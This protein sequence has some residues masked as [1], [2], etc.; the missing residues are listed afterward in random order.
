MICENF[1]R[2]SRP[3]RWDR[4]GCA[5][6]DPASAEELKKCL[7]KAGGRSSARAGMRSPRLWSA[8]R[9]IARRSRS[10]GSER[11]K[12]ASDEHVSLT[13]PRDDGRK[14]EDAAGA[15]KQPASLG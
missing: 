10:A 1:V 14:D 11:G 15:S 3:T 5:N 2:T 13:A 7:N 12:G 6:N 9:T 8:P 4:E